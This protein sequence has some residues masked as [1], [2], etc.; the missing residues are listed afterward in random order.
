MSDSFD[1]GN[2]EE[3]DEDMAQAMA[4]MQ[5]LMGD[6]EHRPHRHNP[7]HQH[8]WWKKYPPTVI[9]ATPAPEEEEES[10]VSW[11]DTLAVPDKPIAAIPD[12]DK[13]LTFEVLVDPNPLP[14][15]MARRLW[16]G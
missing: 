14:L 6:L 2:V 7:Q 12:L 3:S 1:L 10:A 16:I 9:S 11:L 4:W 13:P 8:Q 5:E 15:R